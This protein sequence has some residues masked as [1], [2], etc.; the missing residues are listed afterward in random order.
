[1]DNIL[2]QYQNGNT[3]VTLLED[4]TKIREYDN[5]PV[6]EYPESLDIKITNYCNLGCEYCHES[7]TTKGVHGNIDKLLSVL[8]ELPKGTEIA[9]GGGNPL[10]HPHLF[11]FLYHVKELGLVAN[12]TINQGHLIKYFELIKL[13]IEN[14]YVYGVGISLTSNNWKGV[15]AVMELTTNVVFHIILGIHK[16]SILAEL[17]ERYSNPKVLLLGYKVWGFGKDYYNESI[18]KE[19]TKWNHQLP[20]YFKNMTISFDNLAIEQ[21]NL[22]RLFTEAGWNKFYMGDDFKHTMYI[23]A[24]KEEY[25]PTSRSA[26]RV[27]FNE[28]TLL[29][30][31]KT[32]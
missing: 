13:I 9:I 29:E 2:Y 28:M 23:D 17:K 26:K 19:I 3:L 1:M 12:I 10:D 11:Y 16:H 18:E 20:R 8:K 32:R 24:V 27:P 25:S 4:G 22:K 14:K 31:F 5:I 15:D 21:L 6:S 30:Y 7:S